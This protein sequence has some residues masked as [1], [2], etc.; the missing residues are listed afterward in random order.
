MYKKQIFLPFIRKILVRMLL[1][2]VKVAYE[3]TCF[4]LFYLLVNTLVF[5][6]PSYACYIFEIQEKS[7]VFWTERASGHADYQRGV[8]QRGA[9]EASDEVD[10]RLTDENDEERDR[11]T[12]EGAAGAEEAGRRWQQAGWKILQVICVCVK[13]L[14][15]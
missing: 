14:S 6:V 1:L 8:G 11:G 13:E 2:R 12:E 5:F 7:L 3:Y 4:V 15:V 9:A 10:E